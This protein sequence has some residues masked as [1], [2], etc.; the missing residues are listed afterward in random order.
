M[1]QV[2]TTGLEPNGERILVKRDEAPKEKKKG[3]IIV[4]DNSAKAPN[5]G[6]IVGVGTGDVVARKYKLGYRVVFAP[7]GATEIEI[8]DTEK[9]Y[10]MEDNAVLAFFVNKK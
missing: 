9:Y 7:Y 6:T 10:V 2:N 5:F 1:D 4:A 8:S 3:S